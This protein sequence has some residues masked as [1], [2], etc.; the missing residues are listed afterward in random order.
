[1]T[2]TISLARRT[3]ACPESGGA[4]SI[5]VPAGACGGGVGAVESGFGREK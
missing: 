1:M 2:R 5:P 4:D 3:A